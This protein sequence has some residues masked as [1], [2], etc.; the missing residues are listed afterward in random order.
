[1]SET[2]QPPRAVWRRVAAPKA[3]PSPTG[4]VPDFFSADLDSMRRCGEAGVS[5]AEFRKSLAQAEQDEAA[6]AEAY[7][8][9]QDRLRAEEQEAEKAEKKRRA[10]EED[11][12]KAAERYRNDRYAVKLLRQ[13]NDAWGGD[14]AGSGMLG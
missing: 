10:E 1:M 14:D 7:W 9:E 8:A 4:G 12:V 3:P 13:G 6:R 5:D 2:P 11:D